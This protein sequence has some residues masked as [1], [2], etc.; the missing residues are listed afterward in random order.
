MLIIG[1]T[2]VMFALLWLFD[3]AKVRANW[4]EFQGEFLESINSRM[5]IV[6]FT[7]DGRFH[8]FRNI[9]VER[10]AGVTKEEGHT[11]GV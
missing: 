8:S 3:G 6:P 5:S 1:T 7:L 10:L 2:V 11:G 4:K 9:I